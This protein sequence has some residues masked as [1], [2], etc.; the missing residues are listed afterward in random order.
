MVDLLDLQKSFILAHLGKGDVAADFTMGNGHDTEFLSKTVGKDGH[1]YAFDIQAAALESTAKNLEAAG[2]D[3]NYTLIHD[4][5]HNAKNYIKE[6]IKAGMFNLGWLPGSGNKA[7]TTKLDTTLIAVR[8][9]IEMLDGDGIIL[10]AVYPGHEE[11]TRE[12]Q[13]LQ[14]MLSQYDRRVYSVSKFQIIN[15]PTSPY[16]MIIENR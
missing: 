2:C 11:G 16:F 3:K 5:H 13:A 10:I 15:S 9:A 8:D 6:K 14:D 7:V 4:S 12:G 1:V